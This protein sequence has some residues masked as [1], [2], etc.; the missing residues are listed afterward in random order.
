[1]IHLARRIPAHLLPFWHKLPQKEYNN[2]TA[3]S[4]YV[5]SPGSIEQVLLA[6]LESFPSKPPSKLPTC[7]AHHKPEPVFL[8]G[9]PGRWRPLNEAGWTCPRLLRSGNGEDL[10][11][12]VDTGHARLLLAPTQRSSRLPLVFYWISESQKSRW[13][14]QEMGKASSATRKKT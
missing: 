8:P 6:T 11:R 13:K 14:V 2:Y 3:P 7:L 5:L 4:K 1:M 12:G 10:T 9:G